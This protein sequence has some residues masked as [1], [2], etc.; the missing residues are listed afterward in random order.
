MEIKTMP[1]PADKE[2]QL[3]AP[4]AFDYVQ[5]ADSA[6]KVVQTWS[7]HNVTSTTIDVQAFPSG[8]YWLMLSSKTKTG[9]AGLVIQK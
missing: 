7:V 4:E 3:I 1:N 2:V 9:A 6:G 8:I 5:M